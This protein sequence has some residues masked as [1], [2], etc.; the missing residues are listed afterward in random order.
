VNPS[1]RITSA[2]AL[3]EDLDNSLRLPGELQTYVVQQVVDFKSGTGSND[4]ARVMRLVGR[5]P[6]DE[7]MRAVAEYVAGLE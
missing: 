4:R 2:G 1:L 3:I 6:T 5:R 7:E